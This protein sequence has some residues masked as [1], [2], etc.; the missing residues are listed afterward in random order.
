MQFMRKGQDRDALVGVIVIVAAALLFG[1]VYAKE[2]NSG[3]DGGYS[4]NARFRKADG[5]AL[6]SQVRLSGVVVG[7]VVAE[8]LDN[9]FRAVTTLR[10]ASSLGL[11]SDTAAVIQTDGLLGS[12]YIELRPGAEDTVL[13]PGQEITFTQD[14]MVLEDLMELIINQARAKRGYLDRPL[15]GT[16]Q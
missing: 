1:L 13:L 10:I 14:S 6:G 7:K 15:P 8:E 16:S 3:S 11:P 5:I 12:K 2:M 4:L 9:Q